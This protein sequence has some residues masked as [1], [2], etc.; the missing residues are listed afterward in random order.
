MTLAQTIIETAKSTDFSWMKTPS[1]DQE[2]EALEEALEA[3]LEENPQ[4]ELIDVLVGLIKK[5]EQMAYP[6]PKASPADVLRFL[7]EQHDLKQVDLID[8]FTNQGN[9][10]QVLNGK[11]GMSLENVKGLSRKFNV[12]AAVFIEI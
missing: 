7:M 9:V 2:C 4:S 5:Y 3:L 8:I 1:C 12:S 11:R 10:S 6:I